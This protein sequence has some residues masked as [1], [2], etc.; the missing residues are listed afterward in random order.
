MMFVPEG[1]RNARNKLGMRE[2]MGGIF[3]QGGG[4]LALIL[5]LFEGALKLIFAQ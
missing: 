1:G 5:S 4:R 2:S 3:F